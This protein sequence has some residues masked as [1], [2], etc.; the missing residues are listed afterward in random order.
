M[1]TGLVF[2]IKRFSIHD[3]PGIRTTVFLKGC[4]L[5]CAWCH[6][7]ESQDTKPDVML[8]PGR[9][10]ACEACIEACPE[11]AISTAADGAVVTNMSLCV[12][13][14]TCTETCYA[15]ARQKIGQERTVDEVVETV[16]RDLDFYEESGGGV[17]LS[18][19]EPLVQREFA[20]ELLRA[21]RERGIHTAVDTSG[22]VAWKAIEDVRGHT[23]LFLY[24]IKHMDSDVHRDSTG[25]GNRRI[26][27]NL[28]KLSGLGQALV[29]RFAV[30]PGFNDSDENVR[31]IG[32]FAAGLPRRH[33]LSVLPYHAG[34]ADKYKRLNQSYTLGDIDPPGDDR[35]A[36]IAG[37]LEGYGLE[38][39]TGG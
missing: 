3:G 39:K 23:D 38:V 33:P 10:I 34:A 19:G 35:I 21:C 6:N 31:R 30:I 22:A 18:G 12:R 17:T 29:L 28:E 24:D 14:G 32:E 26:L 5:Q 16:E 4:P 27:A 8:R 25:A 11:H 9:C 13:C 7:P 20:V 2:D 36:E 1:T 15:E 37:I